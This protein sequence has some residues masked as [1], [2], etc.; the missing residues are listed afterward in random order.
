MQEDT[1]ISLS[2]QKEDSSIQPPFGPLGEL[3]DLRTYRRWLSKEGRRE[4]VAERNAR[5]VNYNV[6]LAIG[7]QSTNELQQEADLM[8]EMLNNLQVW[9]S[10]RTAWVGGT[11]T[12]ETHPMS[13]FNCSFTAINRL[14]AFCDLFELLMV[15]AGVGFRVH[16]KDIAKL[17]N[18][19]TPLPTLIFD[20]YSPVE[21]PSRLENTCIKVNKSG[22]LEVY[23]GDSREGWID[24]LRVLFSVYFL[25]EKIISHIQ[26]NSDINLFEI[27][28]ITFNV[29]NIRPIGERINGFGGTASGPKALQGILEDVAKILTD[30]PK[31]SKGS[32]NLRSIDCMDISCAIARGVVAGSSRRSALICLFE[33]GDEL[34]A[35]AKQGLYTNPSLAGKMYRSQSNNTE[36]LGSRELEQLKK[37]LFANPD[38]HLNHE[39]VKDYFAGFAPSIEKL[40]NKFETVKTEGEPGFDNWMRMTAQRFYAAR[41]WRPGVSLDNIWDWY[42]DVGC[43]PCSEIL[44]TTGPGNKQVTFC[45][46]SEIPLTNHLEVVPKSISSLETL[47]ELNMET[48]EQA[49]RMAARIGLRQTCVDMPHEHMDTTQKEERLIGVSATGWRDV[50]D[51]LGW[52]TGDP[53]IK[54]LQVSCRKWANDE[55]TQYSR[56][57]NVPRPLLVTTIKPSGTFSQVVGCGSGLHWDWAPY[58]IRRIRMSANDALAKTLIEQ[59]FPCYP[60][61]YDL[62]LWKREYE[63]LTSK[64]VWENTDNWQRLTHFDRL[65]QTTKKQVLLACNTV[66]FEF[67][68][69]SLAKQ[70]QGSVSAIEQLE[71]MKSFTVNYCDHM[72]SSTITVKEDEWGDVIQWVNDNWSVFTTASFLPYYGGGYPLLPNEEIDESEYTRRLNKVPQEYQHKLPNG[73]VMF[74]VDETLLRKI[75]LQLV[76]PDDVEITIGGCQSGAC[77]LR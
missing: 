32:S 77:P 22:V 7:R 48:L 60:E 38:L 42:C 73:K 19:V 46:L 36:T 17:P 34:C 20:D 72:P 55:A 64:S 14:E 30:V 45:N 8:Y 1:F 29:N 70:S 12:S 24:S 23:V 67:P 37:F 51:A 18:L 9:P 61:L 66:V 43:N 10:G 26:K 71:N 31:N 44:L 56:K 5:V 4:T 16:S 28:G 35:K 76:D 58:Y 47:Y 41:K 68:V 53:R 75:E 59:G 11:Q 15:G 6:G 39:V 27:T 63:S 25:D 21:K 50:F 69:K 13:Q 65:S 54:N 52:K 3:V 2:R 40:E 49:F 33:E 62:S 57:L 74:K